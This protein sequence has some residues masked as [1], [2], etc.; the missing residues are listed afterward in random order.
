MGTRFLASAKSGNH[1]GHKQCVIEAGFSDLVET[2]LFDGGWPASPHRALRNS[3]LAVW[4]A[5]GSPRPG[6]RPNEGRRVGAFP[7][8]RP[9]SRY[10]VAT[11]WDGI[12]GEWAASALCAGVSAALVRDVEP[13]GTILARIAA[14]AEAALSPAL[15]R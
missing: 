6:A 4:E 9:M 5:A 8:G 11:P 10:D 3:T 1:P 7:D 13:V 14:E 12:E 15:P 2:T